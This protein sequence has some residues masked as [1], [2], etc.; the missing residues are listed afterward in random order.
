MNALA[1]KASGDILIFANDDVEADARSIDA[2]IEILH[3][4]SSV[5]IVGS[6]LRKSNGSLCHAGISF[7]ANGS[8]YHQLERFAGSEHPAFHRQ[9][10]CPATTGA[11]FAMRRED[12]LKTKLDTSFQACGEDVLLCLQTR[13][14]LRKEILICPTMSG[15]HN[16]EST[17]SLVEKGVSVE[18]DQEKI[19]SAWLAMKND[20]MK[21]N[22]MET[23]LATA[24]QEA[25][26]LRMRCLELMDEME[27]TRI[28]AKIRTESALKSLSTK[29]ILESA[30]LRKEN[31]RLLARIR[32]L[33]EASSRQTRS[34]S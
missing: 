2:A 21:D 10:S 18:Q 29:N 20:F 1:E 12:F 34:R 25:E 31:D 23:E 4:K 3:N 30:L 9:V 5:G 13:Q 14:E 22:I 15:I 16:A 6:I 32:Q 27:R 26:D 24:Q 28:E 33:E 19:R 17:R 11:F 8:P 7:T